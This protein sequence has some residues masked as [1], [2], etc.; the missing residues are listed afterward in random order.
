MDWDK[1]SKIVVWEDRAMA[2]ALALAA[3]T[4]GFTIYYFTCIS[5]RL[6]KK[7]QERYGE[8]EGQ[9]RWIVFTR[10]LGGFTLGFPSVLLPMLFLEGGAQRYGM[11][12]GMN[13][14]AIIICAVLCPLLIIINIFR[15]GKPGN[16][17]SYPQIRKKEWDLSTFMGSSIGWIVYLLG[18]EICFRGFLLFGCVEAMGVWA[19]IAI[20]TAIYSLAH[21]FKGIG[22]TVGAIPFGIIISVISLYTGNF[23]VAF[24]VHV[25]LA[26]SNQ[27]VAFL[28]HPEMRWKAK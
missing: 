18:Y 8:E 21:H 27:T 7:F 26:L 16:L 14:E 17:V 6:F 13:M 4:I 22:E 25:S 15:A 28:A 5:A 2:P 19:A 24:L 1:L 10:V 20:N 11:S 12:F 3:V 9:A 23:M